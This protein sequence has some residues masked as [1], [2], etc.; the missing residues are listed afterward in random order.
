[1]T[2]SATKGS[3]PLLE[4]AVCSGKTV[5]VSVAYILLINLLN[6]KASTTLKPL[7]CLQAYNTGFIL[8]M[9]KQ[10][11]HAVFHQLTT[12]LQQLTDRQ[13]TQSA[14]TLSGA[15]VGQHVRH[16][17]E[18]FQCLEEGYRSGTVNY[19]NRRRDINIETNRRLAIQLLEAISRQLDKPGRDFVLEACYD[20]AENKPVQIAT[21]YY[22]EIAYN[23]EHTI[24]HMALIRIGITEVARVELPAAFGV[25][26][27]TTKYK[28]QC[29]Q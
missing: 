28:T 4:S 3:A 26:P 20:E 23:L 18:L 13:F 8:V 2:A 27:S 24:H 25:A 12:V 5:S 19:E 14:V 16:I 1:M 29:A 11:I 22:R 9:L 17:I 15:S 7:I 10:T 21:N 6:D